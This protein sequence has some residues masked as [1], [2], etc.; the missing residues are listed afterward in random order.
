MT[1]LC[2]VHNV[3]PLLLLVII[4]SASS[5]DEKLRKS[6]IIDH[7]LRSTRSQRPD[8][9]TDSNRLF[10][11]WCQEHLGIETLLEIQTFYY[12]DYIR[13]MH[14]RID[15]F[16]EDCYHQDDE[17]DDDDD[18]SS[19][20]FENPD[21]AYSVQD[22]PMIPVRGLA[23]G[24]DIQV[25]DVVIRIPHTSLWT[26][27]NSI[28]DDPVLSQVL[29][30]EARD[31]HGWN[32]PLDEI[33][34]LAIALLY[35]LGEGIHS[36]IHPYI[37]LLENTP[38]DS[39][40]HLWDNAKLRHSAT[41]GVRKVAKG[42][43]KD[44][45]DLYESIVMVLVEEHPNVFGPHYEDHE[46]EEEEWL[47]SLERFHW[48]FAIVNSRHWHL[49]IP[50]P[51]EAPSE[52]MQDRDRDL[53]LLQQDQDEVLLAAAKDEEPANDETVESSH[54]S[55]QVNPPAAM[56]TEE[57]LDLKRVEHLKEEEVNNATTTPEDDVYGAFFWPSGNSFLAPVADLL[58]FGPPC[59]RGMYNTET[60]S[61][62]I[63]ATC[64][65]QKGQEVTFWYADACQDVFVA[66]YGFTHP[67]VS[68]TPCP[69][70]HVWQLEQELNFAFDELELLDR[71]LDTALHYLKECDCVK[72]IQQ[73]QQQRQKQQQAE[74]DINVASIP[75]APSPPKQLSK[76]P[77]QQQPPNGSDGNNNARHAI[78]GGKQRF[79]R[80][81]SPKDGLSRGSARRQ[82]RGTSRK[83]DL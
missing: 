13:A 62:E 55:E 15:V 49:P 51:K 17:D 24:Q 11:Q 35:H 78:R 82:Q 48:A 81:A 76:E 19:S 57:W 47:F 10:L 74:R 60:L 54:F 33:P 40:P 31:K 7:G 30:T 77:S 20:F 80:A 70:N 1:R 6:P 39:I 26:I 52:T 3:C 53:Q 27:S 2:N 79:A 66:N 72:K 37:R 58:N 34:L 50:I 43:Q 28:D 63:I 71:E 25:G 32:T 9:E 16:C 38:T 42:I 56:P 41:V 61:F 23:A 8:E 75:A 46:E 67:I 69:D 18:A 65:F 44:V 29:G 73:Q 64:P 12:Y 21:H 36:H 14:D 68:T 4:I 59:T 45:Q 22:Y 83:S 5:A